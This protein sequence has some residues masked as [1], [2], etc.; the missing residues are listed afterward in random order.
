MHPT[1]QAK[2]D[3]LENLLSYGVTKVFVATRLPGVEV[4]EWW[5][6]D[7]IPLDLTYANGIAVNTD[8]EGFVVTGLKSKGVLFSVTAPWAAVVMIAKYDE[9]EREDWSIDPEEMPA[10]PQD[11]EQAFL[12]ELP[13]HKLTRADA[14]KAVHI[15]M[16]QLGELKPEDM[17]RFVLAKLPR[18]AYTGLKLVSD[19][20][21]TAK[22]TFKPMDPPPLHV[23]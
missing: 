5:E 13:R 19:T 22:P 14:I 8:D 16:L 18:G 2:R 17:A 6:G 21:A 1:S 23:A 4:P 15:L 9:S 10:P 7:F 3:K 20:T 12:L 11:H